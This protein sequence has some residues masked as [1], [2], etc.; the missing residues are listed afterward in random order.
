[1]FNDQ[2]V[3]ASIKLS[4]I[5][6][7]QARTRL[8]NGLT[9]LLLVELTANQVVLF[10]SACKNG[11][12]LWELRKTFQWLK[13]SLSS[14]EMRNETF[15]FMFINE[16]HFNSPQYRTFLPALVILSGFWCE[17]LYLTNFPGEVLSP[18]VPQWL[19]VCS[20]T[21]SSPANAFWTWSY[22]R[23]KQFNVLDLLI[24]QKLFRLRRELWARV[25]TRVNL[26]RT[27]IFHIIHFQ[28]KGV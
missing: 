11:I 12:S 13:K 2:L 5:I 4:V 28:C 6:N 10:H 15:A 20:L 22:D 7:F 21:E 19:N 14:P 27:G 8:R 9:K 23:S 1:M 18:C 25:I 17:N 24:P 16:N 26:P 3:V